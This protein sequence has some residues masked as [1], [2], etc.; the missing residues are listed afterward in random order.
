MRSFSR[1]VSRC[2]MPLS[3]LR[4]TK[5][6][7]SFLAMRNFSR[8]D[9]KFS[10]LSQTQEKL[11]PEPRGAWKEPGGARGSQGSQGEPGEPGRARGARRAELAFPCFP[12]FMLQGISENTKCQPP[13]GSVPFGM[14][15]ALRENADVVPPGW[16]LYFLEAQ[17]YVVIN[18][19]FLRQA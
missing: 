14:W 13:G 18:N 11:R 12:L 2:L 16:I 4:K 5:A 19:D 7:A 6:V 9:E 17:L 10:R 8:P 3:N 15:E 1:L